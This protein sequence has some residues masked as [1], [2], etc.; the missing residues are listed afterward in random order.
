VE[1]D[2]ERLRFDVDAPEDVPAMASMAVGAATR[3]WI[4]ARAAALSERGH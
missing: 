4:G 3:G 1:L 2:L